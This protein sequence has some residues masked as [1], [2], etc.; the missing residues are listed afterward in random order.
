MNGV[1]KYFVKAGVTKLSRLAKKYDKVEYWNHNCVD[2]L[3]ACKDLVEELTVM[4]REAK[5]IESKLNDQ[6]FRNYL[7]MR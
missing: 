6:D 3:N 1:R 5:K 4:L 7:K 2:K